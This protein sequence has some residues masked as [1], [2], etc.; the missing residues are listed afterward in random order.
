MVELPFVG[1]PRQLAPIINSWFYAV[2]EPTG[3][4]GTPALLKS[5]S[6]WEDYEVN[7]WTVGLIVV[8]SE[9]SRG[10]KVNL[11][12]EVVGEGFVGGEDL[13]D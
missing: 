6:S 3:G 11:P 1:G 13:L 5:T 2:Q 7:V 9:R 12:F 10:R 8:R 4:R